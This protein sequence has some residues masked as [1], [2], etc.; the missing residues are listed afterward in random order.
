M[1]LG[2]TL[3]PCIYRRAIFYLRQVICDYI[4]NVLLQPSPLGVNAL[5]MFRVGR[6]EN[7]YQVCRTDPLTWTDLLK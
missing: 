2:V 7:V 5:F 3:K 1:G 4:E 6:S